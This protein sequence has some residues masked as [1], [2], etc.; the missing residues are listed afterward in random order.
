VFTR[1][2]P[3]ATALFPTAF[4]DLNQAPLPFYRIPFGI[5]LHVT[6]DGFG[7]KYPDTERLT[8][9]GKKRDVTIDRIQ[10][11]PNEKDSVDLNYQQASMTYTSAGSQVTGPVMSYGLIQAPGN[12][13]V[14]ARAVELHHDSVIKFQDYQSASTLAINDSSAGGQTFELQL[15]QPGP[16]GK[17]KKLSD[18]TVYQPPGQIIDVLYDQIHNGSPAVQVVP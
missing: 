4:T 8:Y 16:D 10:V 6:I 13:T 3:G 9:L 15:S 7:L 14:S 2:F 17:V 1:K 12:Y 11:R 5:S 18:F